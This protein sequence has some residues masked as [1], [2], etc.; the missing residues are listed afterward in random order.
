MSG[1]QIV[2]FPP[3]SSPMMKCQ[4]LCSTSYCGHYLWCL[5]WLPRSTLG[6]NNN[7]IISSWK[8]LSCS[9]FPPPENCSSETWVKQALIWSWDIVLRECKV[10]SSVQPLGRLWG[11]ERCPPSS[12]SSLTVEWLD[13]CLQFTNISVLTRYGYVSPKKTVL[14]EWLMFLKWKASLQRGSEEQE[15]QKR[16][17]DLTM[18]GRT[19]SQALLL[20][21]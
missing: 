18:S 20:Q 10:S 3:F 16:L 13:G 15:V 6:S 9:S 8:R 7:I 12:P 19:A 14:K 4:H 17:Q 21:Q 11:P 5:G 2:C 1:S